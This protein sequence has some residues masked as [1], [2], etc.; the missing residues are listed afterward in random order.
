M[1]GCLTYTLSS[2]P[3]GDLVMRTGIYVEEVIEGCSCSKI[4]AYESYEGDEV[5]HDL[6]SDDKEVSVYKDIEGQC[7]KCGKP[8]SYNQYLIVT[9]TDP[10]KE[11][12]FTLNQN[13]FNLLSKLIMFC[14]LNSEFI[15]KHDDCL[16]TLKDEKIR[17]LAKKI[18]LGIQ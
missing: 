12:S 9:H 18:G 14:Y 3:Q 17:N 11:K 15:K 2:K 6:T 10:I 4:K 7:P 8:V 5:F 16:D 13:E 1:C